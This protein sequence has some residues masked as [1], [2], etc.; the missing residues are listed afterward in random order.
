MEILFISHSPIETPLQSSHRQDL[1]K[2]KVIDIKCSV[3]Q[4][5]DVKTKQPYIIKVGHCGVL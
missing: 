2:F 4:V 5:M 3:M 1:K